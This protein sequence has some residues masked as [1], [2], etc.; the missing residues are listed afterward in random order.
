MQL[1]VGLACE[2]AQVDRLPA[3]V[4][5]AALPRAAITTFGL[6]ASARATDSSADP[7]KLKSMLPRNSAHRAI[8]YFVLVKCSDCVCRRPGI[9]TTLLFN[10]RDQTMDVSQHCVHKTRRGHLVDDPGSQKVKKG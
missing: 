7:V 2:L 8:M 4:I 5:P 1:A 10:S 9:M 6:S 3:T